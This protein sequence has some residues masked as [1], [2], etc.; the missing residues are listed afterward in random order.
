[1]PE[2]QVANDFSLSAQAFVLTMSP[3]AYQ[4]P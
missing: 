1:M 2:C 3:L 4:M